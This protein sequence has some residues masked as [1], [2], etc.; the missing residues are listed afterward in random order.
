MSFDMGD[1]RTQFK[2]PALFAWLRKFPISQPTDEI[3]KIS[4]VTFLALI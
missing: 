2:Q 4:S 3:S 1:E